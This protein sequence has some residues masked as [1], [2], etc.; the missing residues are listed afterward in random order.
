MKFRLPTF[1]VLLFAFS[2]LWG[3]QEQNLGL[4]SRLDEAKSLYAKGEY[5]G[6][7]KAM[8]SAL[9]I[10][11]QL[12]G[13]Q[14]IE[15]A[16]LENSLGLIYARDGD[17]EQ[18]EI[19]FNHSIDVLFSSEKGVK[20]TALDMYERRADM[21]WAKGEA[22]RSV[23]N[24]EKAISL[25][26][27]IYGENSTVEATQ[28]TRIGNNYLIKEPLKAETYYLKAISILEKDPLKESQLLLASTLDSL[29]SVYWRDEENQA[30]KVEACLVRALEIYKKYE[31][32]MARTLKSDLDDFHKRQQA[33]R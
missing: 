21:Y 11:S 2:S 24:S 25:A 28:L 17:Y 29:K 31:H 4:E 1:L 26:R 14:S 5:R 27:S 8:H 32:P 10:A 12:Y 7:I 3:N 18:A 30:S 9:D 33:R 13:K 19:Y 6:A 16:E 23:E 20:P 22:Q 15:Y